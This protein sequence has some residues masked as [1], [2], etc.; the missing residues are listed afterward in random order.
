[1]KKIVLSMIAAS[2]ILANNNWIKDNMIDVGSDMGYYQT[3]TRGIYTLG[4]QTIKF[5]EV[6]GA[7]TPFH[8][9]PPRFNVGCGGIDIAMGGF[10]YLNPEFI[11]EKLKAISAAA[12]AFVY[13]MAI[14]ALCKD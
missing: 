5:R 11:I 8:L 10:S 1:M 7:I 9:D 2:M 3:Q 14:S 13:Q 12:P 4:S 6:G